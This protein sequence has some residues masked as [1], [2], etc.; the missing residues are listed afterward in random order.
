MALKLFTFRGDLPLLLLP[1]SWHLSNLPVINLS[2]KGICLAIPYVER[3]IIANDKSRS[4]L[5]SRD[6]PIFAAPWKSKCLLLHPAAML[7]ISYFFAILKPPLM[8]IKR[9]MSRVLR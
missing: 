9:P 7:E 8:C 2:F 4:S 6:K 1:A 5:F 3:Q